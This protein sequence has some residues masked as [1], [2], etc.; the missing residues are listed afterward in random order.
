M[1]T[2]TRRFIVATLSH[3]FHGTD[4]HQKNYTCNVRDEYAWTLHVA[5][6]SAKFSALAILSRVVFRMIYG[7]EVG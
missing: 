1:D 3:I 6:A 5:Q 2:S 4:W 7:D